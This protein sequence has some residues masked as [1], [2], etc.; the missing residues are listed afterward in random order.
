MEIQTVKI[1][2]QSYLLNGTMSVPKADGN[3][4]YELIKEWLAE[5]N[6]PEPEFTEA[7]LLAK[8]YNE[9]LTAWKQSRQ[10]LVD[11]IEVTLDTVVYQGDELSQ[12]RMSRAIVALPDDVTTVPWV[13]KDNTVVQLN[14][15]QLTELLLQAGQAQSMIWNEGRPVE[16]VL[17]GMPVLL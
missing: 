7:E 4:E 14:K 6:I 2:G 8:A 17:A 9:A 1:Q 12:T 11:N 15:V 5:G 13:A 3:R 16:E 10:T